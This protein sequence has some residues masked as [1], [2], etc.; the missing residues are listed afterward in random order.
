MAVWWDG[1]LSRELL[2]KIYIDKWIGNGTTR[3]FNG[4]GKGITWCN[5]TKATPCLSA[6]IFGDWREEVIWPTEDGREIRIYMTDKTT[7]YG[8]TTLMQDPIYRIGVATENAGYNQPPEPGFYFGTDKVGLK[9]FL[10][11]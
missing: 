8:I 1:D 5:G 10:H 11:K 2:D 7:E 4:K 9:G 3:I 6:D